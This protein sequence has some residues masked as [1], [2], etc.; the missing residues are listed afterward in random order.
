MYDIGNL[1][2]IHLIPQCHYSWYCLC[3]YKSLKILGAE[4]LNISKLVCVLKGKE[5]WSFLSLGSNVSV[6]T[7]VKQL[8]MSVYCVC[9]ANKDMFI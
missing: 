7:G 1:L 3:L 9:I 5:S 4:I 6:I 8:Y 2:V